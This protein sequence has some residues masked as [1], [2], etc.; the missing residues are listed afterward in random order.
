MDLKNSVLKIGSGQSVLVDS[1]AGHFAVDLAPAS[2]LALKD[3]SLVRSE[4][5][6]LPRRLEP[7][8][9]QG[10]PRRQ[11]Y[12]AEKGSKGWVGRVLKLLAPM[13]A[14]ATFAAAGYS[15]TL[16]TRLPR[17]HEHRVGSGPTLPRATSDHHSTQLP[18]VVTSGVVGRRDGCSA[19][20][21]VDPGGWLR[22]AVPTRPAPP[23]KAQP[24]AGITLG[25]LPRV[26]AASETL[27]AGITLGRL[28]RVRAASKKLEANASAEM[29]HCN[30]CGRH[31]VVEKLAANNSDISVQP[32]RL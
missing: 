6:A 16:S 26:R 20:G 24:T 11:V 31:A 10:P 8:R 32:C 19:A 2:W 17:S 25:R 12:V 27:A 21:V 13:T 29:G 22:P 14:C 9:R 18:P 23:L 7:P 3:S 28:P 15:P 30:T 4:A 5:A 1:Q